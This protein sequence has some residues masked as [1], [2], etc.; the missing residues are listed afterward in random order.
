[1]LTGISGSN[2]VE[3]AAMISGFKAAVFSASAANAVLVDSGAAGVGSGIM[4]RGFM[5]LSGDVLVA[6][7]R[8][9]ERMP[10]QARALHP[11]RKLTHTGEHR[12]L[13]QILGRLIGWRRH[14]VMK[15]LEQFA[16]FA[17]GVA[18]DGIGH[19]RRGRLR[20]GTAATLERDVGDHVAVDLHVQVQPITAE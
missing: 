4:G 6:L 7:E 11:H 9:L 19:E 15:T 10:R 2:T 1:M 13:S 14:Y 20:N 3:I 18:L 5:L 16:G 12:Q 8:G 17:D